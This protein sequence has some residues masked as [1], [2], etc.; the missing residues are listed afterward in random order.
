LW[1]NIRRTTPEDLP[2]LLTSD[3]AVEGLSQYAFDI[4]ALYD[5][6]R[7]FLERRRHCEIRV[8]SHPRSHYVGTD[9]VWAVLDMIEAEFNHLAAHQL[10]KPLDSLSDNERFTLQYDIEGWDKRDDLIL[11]AT[12][13]A[14]GIA[15]SL[16][17]T[18]P[19]EYTFK[20]QKKAGRWADRHKKISEI[21]W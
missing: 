20:F 2:Y 3:S 14:R 13:V 9:N 8:I 6:V 5:L 10:N 1:W 15:D 4:P 17:S 12:F 21:L 19:E 11:A 7:D 18:V 16:G